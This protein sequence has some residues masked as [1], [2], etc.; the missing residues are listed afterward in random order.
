VFY[1]YVLVDETDREVYVGFTTDLRRRVEE[2]R[3]GRGAKYTQ[4]G[5]WRLAYYEAFFSEADAR[6]R[7]KKLKHD[8]R[9][10][11]QLYARIK[12]SFAGQK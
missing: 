3:S 8:G 2:H 6:T 9:A 5:D 10:R 7:E 4:S 12:N 1:V 11:Y